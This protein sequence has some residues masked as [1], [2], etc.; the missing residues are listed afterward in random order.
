VKA[1]IGSVCGLITVVVA[2]AQIT[3]I[4]KD[5]S[6][7]IRV[8]NDS[9]KNLVAFAV[10]ATRANGSDLIMLPTA[11]DDSITVYVD[12]TADERMAPI[13]PGHER[14]VPMGHI[15]RAPG[16]G[17]LIG[18]YKPPFITAGIFAD[19]TTTGNAA[20][21]DRLIVRRSNVLQAVEI[22]LEILT[23]AGNSNVQRDHFIQQFKFMA[24]SARRWYVPQ[25][26]RVASD[27]YQSVVEKLLNLPEGPPGSPFPPDAFVAQETGTLNRLRVTLLDS[28][29]SLAEA[30]AIR[31]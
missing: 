28:Q 29:P 18:I 6:N 24:D 15:L 2:T 23:D 16:K 27:V 30:A 9:A 11:T 22:S 4:P 13:T 7:E 20:L 25:D 1:L 3:I 31:R 21:L 5:G 17:A 12:S 26:Q 8:R 14:I 10:R 19:G